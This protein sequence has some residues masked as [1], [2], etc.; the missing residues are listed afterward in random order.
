MLRKISVLDVSILASNIESPR[1]VNPYFGP[2]VNLFI[3][4]SRVVCRAVQLHNQLQSSLAVREKSCDM[5][6]VET[7]C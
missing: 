3:Y 4:R 1:A 7:T 5:Q 6:G 2:G